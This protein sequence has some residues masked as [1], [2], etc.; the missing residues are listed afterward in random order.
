MSKFNELPV[1]LRHHV[2]DIGESVEDAIKDAEK[3]L[4][5][6]ELTQEQYETFKEEMELIFR[7]AMS[8]AE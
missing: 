4:E 1:F 2:N 3:M 6:G 5:R 7:N 8:G